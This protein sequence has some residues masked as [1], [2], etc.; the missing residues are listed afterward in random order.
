[1]KR[2]RAS[3]ESERREEFHTSS[4]LPL[5][6]CYTPQDLEAEGFAYER[7]LGAPGQF[8]FT[9][10]VYPNMYRSRLWTMRQY[11]GYGTA[12][13]SNRRFRY[14]IEQGQT[15]LSVAFDLPT[16][17]G[18]DSDHPLAAGEVG[19][20]GVAIDS[21]PDME[22][23]F[24]GIG[25]D[26]VSTSMTINA[27]AS[28]LLCLY[29]AV[30]RRRGADTRKLAGTVQND[31]LKEYVARGT[32]IYPPR[33]AMRLVTDLFAWCR[34]EL[35]LWNTISISGYH[36]REAGATA[37]QELAFTFAHA[38]AYVQAALDAGLEIDQFAPRLSFF[39][40]AHNDLLEEVAK[41]RAA[42]RLWA[43]MARE[44]FGA[45]DPRSMAL[46][47]HAQTAGSTLT[48][49]Q[50]DINLVRT[51]LQA[52]A[53]VLGG[54]QSLHTNSRDEALGLPTGEAALLALRTQQVIAFESGV[55]GSV[56]PL[57]G[58]YLVEHLTG[59]LERAAR[60]YLERIEAL[61]GTLHAIE[62]GYLQREIQ[63]AAY[64]YQKAVESGE[65][66]VVGVNRFRSEQKTPV[67]VLRVDAALE[68]A[69]IE[70]LGN[71]RATRDT[72]A[73]ARALSELESAARSSR[74]LMPLILA[75]V[76]AY[77]TVGEISDALGRVFGAYRESVVV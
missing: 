50:P 5:A 27:T 9:R 56:D 15:G 76:E 42:R 3:S 72:A 11:A 71:V 20:V 66:V 64:D 38:A 62:T 70:R 52:L 55:A 29:V 63:K 54:A 41:F 12:E 46:R 26:Q 44:R 19:R 13:E 24:D 36:M 69:Q 32:Y 59:E 14:L 1:M 35:P 74:N 22:A 18:L 4:G 40:N 17:M 23:L 68:R 39:F 2:S 25:L 49:Q 61:G 65:Q 77:C 10:G 51:T 67:P 7:S 48:A 16:Q 28:T 8:P 60:D 57:G 47:F 45:R 75:A 43:W 58:S 33:P 31:I 21:L 73:A 34:D 53:A 37:A 6:P 30:A